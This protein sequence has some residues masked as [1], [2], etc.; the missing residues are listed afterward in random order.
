MPEIT[1]FE[2][3]LGNSSGGKRHSVA[4]IDFKSCFPMEA[5]FFINDR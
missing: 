3:D 1:P 4:S 5:A 2:P